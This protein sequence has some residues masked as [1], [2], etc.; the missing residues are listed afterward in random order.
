M[1][2]LNQHK[3]SLLRCHHYSGTEEQYFFRDDP[4]NSAMDNTTTTTTNSTLD[5]LSW[6]RPF[7]FTNS[8][9][10]NKKKKG[11]FQGRSNARFAKMTKDAYHEDHAAKAWIRG[12]IKDMGPDLAAELLKD[13]GIVG[14]GAE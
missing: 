6:K 14:A 4:R 5:E 12:F 7:S 11:S 9:Y 10:T 3:H 2:E 13:V 1:R 8:N